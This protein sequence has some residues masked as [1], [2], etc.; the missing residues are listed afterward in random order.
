ML[1]YHFWIL[2]KIYVVFIDY[3]K[4]TRLR[5]I[6]TEEFPRIWKRAIFL[7][8]FFQIGYTAGV[9]FSCISRVSPVYTVGV[10]LPRNLPPHISNL[11]S[12]YII[13]YLFIFVYSFPNNL[14]IPN[15]LII[16]FLIHFKKSYY[17]I[18]ILIIIFT[19][20][21]SNY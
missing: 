10:W 8:L 14:F 4:L 9:T 16:L 13:Q 5:S 2:G 11:Y 6:K 12:I 3:R 21:K 1:M 15:I 7:W 19:C 17:W 18:F 20:M